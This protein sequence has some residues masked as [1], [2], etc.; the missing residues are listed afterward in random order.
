MSVYL[1]K[2]KDGSLKSPYYQFD[3]VL[4]VNGER[5]RVHGST[6]ETKEGAAR[7]HEKKEK[8]RV[9]AERPL[10]N[11][12]LAAACFRFEEEIGRHR[13]SSDDITTAYAHCCR[14]I[15]GAR[16]LINLT[17]EDI[18]TAV[19]KRSAETYGAKN[20][21]LVTPATVNRQIVEPM[22]RLMRRARSVWNMS[23]EP[24]RIPW[25]DLKMKEP[26]GRN[27]EFTTEESDIF[28]A[29]LRWDYHPVILFLAGRGFRARSAI[30]MKKFDVDLKNGTANVWKKGVGM[31]KMR[32]AKD[33]CDLILAAMKL[34][35]NS[36]FIWTYVKQKGKD[37][38]KRFPV[39]YSGLRGAINTAFRQSGIT[40][41]KIHDLRHDFA[42]KLL[43]RTS[44]LALV[45]DA[46]A[47]SDI[48]STLRY[49]HV[50]GDDIAR[51]MEGM[52]TGMVPERGLSVVNG[53]KAVN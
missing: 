18:A 40:D 44:N 14:L 2:R 9:K 42:S 5:R 33:Q 20:P 43:R 7:L 45:K 26:E 34:C 37:K 25:K 24:D 21:K 1:A 38:G 41:F 15:G 12:T 51:G 49:A 32:L 6:G 10:D 30:G 50:L 29:T 47:H 28:W 36:P 53:K 46:L 35:P 11:M 52:T 13:A 23:C 17:A 3:F 27:R 48:K 19:R 16:I 31:T 8:T 4:K 22:M 39:T